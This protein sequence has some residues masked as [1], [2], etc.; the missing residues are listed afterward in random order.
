MRNLM[1]ALDIHGARSRNRTGTPLRAGD[2]KSHA[3]TSFAIR[4]VARYCSAQ[5]LSRDPERIQA[6]TVEREIY[7]SVPGEASSQWPFS[8]LNLAGHWK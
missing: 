1:R 8:R 7:T 3:S 2:F 4:A 6:L 5:P